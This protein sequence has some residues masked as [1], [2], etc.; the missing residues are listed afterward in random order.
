MIDEFQYMEEYICWDRA[1]KDK[2]TGIV[3]GYHG[4]SESKVVPMLVA[5]SYVGWLRELIMEKFKG[6]RL[7]EKSLNPRLRPEEAWSVCI[8]TV[9]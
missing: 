6:G 9:S 2:A 7:R 1:R 8:S 5:G 3:G 4:L